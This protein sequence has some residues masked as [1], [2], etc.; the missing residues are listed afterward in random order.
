MPI[1]APELLNK[2]TAYCAEA[3]RC[4]GQTLTKLRQWG[5]TERQ[6]DEV[7][8]Y[9][10]R[11]R[12]LDDARYAGAYARDK[13]RFNGW[14]KK[15]IALYLRQAGVPDAC[16]AE[17]LEALDEDAYRGRLAALLAAK[18]KSLKDTDPAARAKLFRFALSRGFEPDEIARA[19]RDVL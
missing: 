18:R 1:S 13:F 2:A 10:R 5:A 11:H 17:A 9:L 16:I 12:Y 15:K 3:E 19:L 7:M 4:A 8:D 6:V 14:G